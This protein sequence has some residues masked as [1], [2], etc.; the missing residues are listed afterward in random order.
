L[1]GLAAMLALPLIMTALFVALF[2]GANPLIEQ[3]ISSIR[4]PS[5]GQIFFWLIVLAMVWPSLRPHR[6]ATSHRIPD[7]E[8]TLPGSS[9]PSVLIS[10]A[11]FNLV[12]AIENGLDIAFLWSGAPLPAGVTMTDYVHRGAYPLIATALLAGIFVL[13]TLKPGSATATNPLIRRLVV[14][15]IAQNMLLV[16]SSVLRTIEYIEESMLT[17]WRIAA[18]L[19]MALVALG[20]GLICWRMLTERSA[21]WLINT[22]ALAAA[23]VLTA[24]TILDFSAMSAT[25]NV[26]HA[27][28]ATGH[29]PNLDLCFLNMM[30][31]PA[32]LPLIELEKRPLPAEFR[33]R[34]RSVRDQIINNTILGAGLVSDQSDWQSWTWRNARRLAEARR[35]LGDNPPLPAPIP[36]DAQ[37]TCDGSIVVSEAVPAETPGA[38]LTKGTVQ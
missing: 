7:A 5:I 8:L 37:R 3:A 1:R 29:G 34:V 30:G 2:A 26:R 35:R 12:F 10:L 4:L 32:L 24:S 25:W 19:W 17:P 31:A 22:N 6:W 21:R 20:L 14:A 28:E 9:T 16:A 33:D 27:A 15:W 13:G 36:G 11:L 23:I 38:P 18:L